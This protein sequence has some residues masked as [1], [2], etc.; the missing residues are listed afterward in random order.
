[1][2]ETTQS[3]PTSP[4][5]VVISGASGL[6]G[7]ELTRRLEAQGHTVVRLVRRAPRGAGEAQWDPGA[8]RLDP[9]ALE[10]A[11]AVVH[12]SGES[13][14]E[15]WTTEKRRR[16]RASRVDSTRLVAGT[17]AGL[18]R[19]PSVLVT[20][21]AVGIYGSRGDERLDEMSAPGSD[22]LAGVVRE[23]EE[24]A[25]PAIDAG[26]RVA[27][28]RFGVVLS[29]R[30]GALAKMLPPFRL[31][32]GGPMGSGRQWM[33]WL[34]LPD[35][36][37][38]VGRA[39][40]DRTWEGPINAVAGSVTNADFARTLGRVLN[41]PALVPVPTFALKLAFGEMAEGTILASQRVEPRRLMQLGYS[42]HHP[43]LEGALRAAIA[44]G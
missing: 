21:S 29:A 15:R 16:I 44:E 20:A 13:V 2:S 9:A 19:K 12:L 34:S 30:D 22:F 33:S 39:L 37:D 32:A 3:T 24:A 41:R 18:A 11:D 4:L 6:I 43:E 8:G 23:W 7:S 14:A 10:G 1:M 28:L 40:V 31:G 17:I 36:V 35:A 5:R 38:L 27:L 25:Q 26:V 42:F